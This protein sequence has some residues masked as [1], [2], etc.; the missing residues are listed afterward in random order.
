[1]KKPLLFLF[2][3]IAVASMVT[4]C[5]EAADAWSNGGYSND[6]VHPVYGTHDWV[7]Q[8]AL[9]WLPADEKQYLV[10]NLAAYL[11]GTEL[12]DNNNASVIGHTGDTTKHHLL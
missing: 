5:F 12:P 2:I 7:A 11:Y 9:D 8:H 4:C 1:M 10:D 3:M 6:S